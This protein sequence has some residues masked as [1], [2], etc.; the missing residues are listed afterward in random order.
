LDTFV[1][2]E[3]AIERRIK[4]ISGQEKRADW[5]GWN[6]RPGRDN[7]RTIVML[8]GNSDPDNYDLRIPA[9]G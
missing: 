5:R 7:A 1:V 6:Y 9:T 8:S 4:E 2:Y 3:K